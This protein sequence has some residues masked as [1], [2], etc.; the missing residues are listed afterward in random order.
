MPEAKTASISKSRRN[1]SAV[2]DSMS[3]R[4]STAASTGR[5]KSALKSAKAAVKAQYSEMG[6]DPDED[7]IRVKKPETEKESHVED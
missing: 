2:E 6:K 1:S 7:D 5:R 4:G 3:A